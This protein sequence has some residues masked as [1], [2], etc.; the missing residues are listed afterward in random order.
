[1]P[2]SQTKLNAGNLRIL[3]ESGNLRQICLG[4]FEVLRMIYPSVRAVGWLTVIPT[5]SEEKI[6]LK[7]DSFQISYNAYYKFNDIEF[8]AFYS[9]SGNAENKIHFSMKGKALSNFQKNRLGFCILHPIEECSGKVCKIYHPDGST[10]DLQ[11]PKLISPHQPFK[12]ISKMEWFLDATSKAILT[13]KGDVFETEDQRNWT[14]ASYKTYCTPLEIPFPVN[15]LK[16]EIIEQE[17]ILEVVTSNKEIKENIEKT[18]F[19]SF[20]EK[21]QFKMPLIGIGKSTEQEILTSAEIEWLKE[22]YFNHYRVE[23][24]LFDTNWKTILLNAYNETKI[25]GWKLELALFFSTNFSLEIVEFINF[26]ITNSISISYASLFHK[27]F[28]STPTELSDFVIPEIKKICSDCKIGVGT[29]SNF[30]QINRITPSLK[31][32]D[33]LTYAAHP[34]EHAFDDLTLIENL[35]GQKYT[36]ETAKNIANGLPVYISPI[37]I[38]RRF[39]ANTDKYEKTEIGKDGLPLQTDTRQMS[40]FVLAWTLGS[41]KNCIESGASFITFYQT[42]GTRG[43]LMGNSDCYYPIFKA[44]KKSVYP[45]YFLFR[46]ILKYKDSIIVKSSSSNPLQISSLL[47][48][49]SNEQLLFIANHCNAEKTICVESLKNKKA[50]ILKINEKILPD[51]LSNPVKYYNYEFYQIIEKI[52]I[53]ANSLYIIKII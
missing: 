50:E 4:N 37:T 44:S 17:I 29:N 41:I 1:M 16:D 14:D 13:L 30:T 6:I 20:D 35:A 40:L 52:N 9:I 15:V 10:S 23:L 21:Q 27:D 7:E 53:N 25:F 34:Q 31:N 2:I 42:T 46:E 8:E 45:I 3:Y 47:I 48:K 33:Y 5:I 19:I 43:I 32:V 11:F 36:V 22:L 28:H 18:I 12:N 26:I 24:M 51:A 39:N 49:T 38:K